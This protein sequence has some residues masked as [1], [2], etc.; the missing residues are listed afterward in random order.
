MFSVDTE[1]KSITLSRGDT[2]AMTITVDGYTF[3]EDDRCVFTIKNGNGTIVKQQAYPMVNNSF[4]V[5]F[6]NADTDAFAAG[7]YTWDVRW[8]IHP[9]YDE[10]GNV[11][12]GDQILT[13]DMPL[14]MTL[15][16]VVGDI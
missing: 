14:D 10:D 13:P 4:T 2:G 12:D 8:V 16:S 15:L 11:V 7:A 6:H 9:Y 3:G 1:N 5:T